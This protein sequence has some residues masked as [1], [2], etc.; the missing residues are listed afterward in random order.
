MSRNFTN[1]EIQLVNELLS[2]GNPDKIAQKANMTV[3]NLLKLKEELLQQATSE[4]LITRNEKK[5]GRND[6]CPCGSGR[7]FKH[8]HGKSH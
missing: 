1:R 4:Q 3:D 5:I 6:P 8:C 7:K 2:G